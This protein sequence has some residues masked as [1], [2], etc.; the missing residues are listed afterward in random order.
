[1]TSWNSNYI[2][3]EAIESGNLSRYSWK[4]L[5]TCPSYVGIPP[6]GYAKSPSCRLFGKAKVTAPF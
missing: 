5:T 3:F 6:S 1:M 4:F 2:D